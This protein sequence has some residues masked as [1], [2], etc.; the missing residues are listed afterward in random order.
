MK[1]ALVILLLSICWQAQAQ[2]GFSESAS[3]IKV[4]GGYSKDFPGLSGY[5]LIGE[6]TYSLHERFEG[7]FGV[8]RINMSGYPRTST[9]E[10]YTKATTLDFNIYFLALAT[11]KNVLRIGTGYSFSFYKTR[12]SYPLVETQNT[13]KLTTW[14]VNDLSG[15]S[16]GIILSADYEYLFSE[17]FSLGI[18]ASLCKAYDRM[19]YVGPFVGIRL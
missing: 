17:K 7:G 15:R 1:K 2:N 8:K 16:S 10:E 19:F 9:V 11:E 5:A 6:Y 4:G 18:K 3:T 13:E 12:R 14:P